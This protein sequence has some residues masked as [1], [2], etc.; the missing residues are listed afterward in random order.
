MPKDKNKKWSYKPSDTVRK[1]IA[2]WE[3]ADFAKQNE[4]FGGDAIAA[5]AAEFSNIM[6][7]VGAS[8]TSK[9]LDGLFSTYYNLR[10]VTFKNKILP[11]VQ[12]YANDLN[13]DPLRDLLTNRYTWTA[14]Q[15]QNGIRNRAAA[16]V[17]LMGFPGTPTIKAPLN[18]EGNRKTIV[19]DWSTMNTPMIKQPVSNPTPQVPLDNEAYTFG[20]DINVK[21]PTYDGGQL[22]NIDVYPEKPSKSPFGISLSLPK[23]SEFLQMNSPYEYMKNKIA[24]ILG[25]DKLL[26]PQYNVL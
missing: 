10:P 26:P 4:M 17:A 24:N 25:I 2:K 1:H 21:P 8:L 9:E 13:V 20:Q 16:D 22:E 3:G 12:Q 14:K 23:L 11:A 19:Q 15:Y 18:V 6:Q 7:A 5:K